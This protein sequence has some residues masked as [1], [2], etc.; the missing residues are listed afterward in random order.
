MNS[1]INRF[2]SDE[3]LLKL[4]EDPYATSKDPIPLFSIKLELDDGSLEPQYSV[5]PV[6]LVST[7]MKIFDLGIEKLQEIAQIEQ[8]LMSHLFKKEAHNMNLKV[9]VR[10]RVEPVKE[11]P[12]DK[13]VLEDENLWLWEAYKT[14]RSE[15]MNAIY[16]MDEFISCEL[17]TKLK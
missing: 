16:P 7:I 3:D 13:S 17:L 8:K 9:T 1:I 12:K 11:D 6:D 5:D 2:I 15:L 10:P 14:L 4:E